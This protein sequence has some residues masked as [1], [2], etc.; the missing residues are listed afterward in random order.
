L[1]QGDEAPILLPKSYRDTGVFLGDRGT[2]SYTNAAAALSQEQRIRIR[3][4]GF[5]DPGL[6]SLG[7]RCLIVPKEV[8]RQMYASAQTYSPDGT[9]T[10]GFFLWPEKIGDVDRLQKE[11]ASRFEKAGISKYWKIDS[12]ERYE[13]SK[14]LLQ[15]F[16]SDRLLFSLI[17][18][19]ILCVA[20]C[21][22]IALL[23]LLIN[24]KKREIAIL[25]SMGASPFS[26]ALI[27]ALSGTA[28]GL[29]SCLLGSLF[30]LLTLH[31]LP[32]LISCLSSV[33]GGTPFNPLLFGH[34][35]ANQLSSEALRFVL[36]ATPLLSL[37]AA[38]LPAIKACKI[39][40]NTVLRSE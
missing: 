29:I 9:P 25:Q 5:Y 31:N 37:I 4:A 16:R 6:L 36:I 30:A 23:I 11:I 10:N 1:P 40:A 13:F 39:R 7:N 33:Q 12:F 8:T 26:I 28:M 22:I 18:A 2:L 21:N 32:A 20:C 24:D 17:G 19:I 3:V 38:L 34:N 15:Q 27:F 14:D 35:L